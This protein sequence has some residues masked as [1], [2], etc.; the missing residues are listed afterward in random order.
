METASYFARK[1]GL[2]QYLDDPAL[3]NDTIL[4]LLVL[5]EAM[6]N[7]AGRRRAA[8]P[9]GSG[10]IVVRRTVVGAFTARRSGDLDY[11]YAV[12]TALRAATAPVPLFQRARFIDMLKGMGVP[13]D[14]SAAYAASAALSDDTHCV[15]PE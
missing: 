5:Q 2:E 10:D 1:H 4:R 6:Q 8:E 3:L 11:R 13:G 12:E 15:D 7:E 14:R 9:A